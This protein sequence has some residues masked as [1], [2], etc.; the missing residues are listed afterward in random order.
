MFLKYVLSLFLMLSLSSCAISYVMPDNRFESPE[1]RAK[2]GG[3]YLKAGAG[4]GKDVELT[5]DFSQIAI[6]TERPIITRSGFV[7]AGGAYAF[8]ERFDLGASYVSDL[9][10]MLKGKYQI[11]GTGKEEK[12]FKLALSLHVGGGSETKEE[13]SN[14]FTK[15]ELDNKFVGGDLILG[16]RINSTVL[17]Y[18]SFFT[19]VLSYEVNQTRST[20]TTTYKGHSRNLGFTAG[21]ILSLSDV[22]DFNLEY[23][24]ATLKTAQKR[25]WMNSYG[26]TLIASF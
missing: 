18:T 13:S 11:L 3:A 14:T 12:D 2:K 19:D 26:A 21:T 16:Y 17:P 7:T 8:D 10:F 15:A 20:T 1:T 24:G 25:K 23:A 22:I 9:G 4:L 6:N 5:P